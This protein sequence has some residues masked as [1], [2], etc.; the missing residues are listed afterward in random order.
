MLCSTKQKKPSLSLSFPIINVSFFHNN[1][2]LKNRVC[3]CCISF[4]DA[5]FRKTF[6]GQKKIEI[7]SISFVL[8]QPLIHAVGRSRWAHN[9]DN[10]TKKLT[11]VIFGIDAGICCC[12]SKLNPTK[13]SLFSP[14]W[15]YFFDPQNMVLA[16]D[17]WYQFK[18]AKI[19]SSLWRATT[20]LQN[21]H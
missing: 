18:L 10:A 8:K 4:I 19:F 12:G 20:S 1:H 11:L 7:S 2:N 21:V 6:W 3:V 5:E 15:F 17:V 14:H 9:N 16:G 13:K